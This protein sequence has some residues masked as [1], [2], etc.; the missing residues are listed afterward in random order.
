MNICLVRPRFSTYTGTTYPPMGLLTIAPYFDK[1]HNIIFHDNQTMVGDGRIED[2][3]VMA[4]SAFT[5]QLWFIEETIKSIREL[6]Q[7]KNCKFVVGGP[8]VTSNPEYAKSLVPSADLLFA[9]DGEYLAENIEALVTSETKLIDYRKTPY[10]LDNKKLPSW[11]LI[12]CKPYIKTVGLAVETS[13]GCPFNCVMCTAHLTHGKQWIPRKTKEI[14]DELRTLKQNFGC[15]KFYFADDNATVDP[16][17]WFNLMQTL[18][19]SGLNLDLSVP[20]GIQAHHLDYETLVQMWFAGLRHFTIGAESGSNRVLDKVIG[21]GGLT[22]EKIEWVVRHAI[23]ANLKPSCFFVIG[24]PG[25][26]L[27]EA[28]ATVDFAEKLRRL[29]AESCTVRNAI[30]MPGTRMFEIAK[31]EGYLTVSEDKLFDFNFVHNS[32]HLLST[33]EW[34]AEQIDGLVSKAKA[35]EKKHIIRSNIFKHPRATLNLLIHKHKS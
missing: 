4:F 26:T 2:Y 23:L 24:F 22:V 6:G 10:H 8:G 20:E 28:Q 11:N 13:R 21:K 16:S 32:K 30:P 19:A 31:Q 33:K 7:R 29:G 34:S 27:Q 1:K 9:G 18:G 35:Q 25:E 15:S 17:R 3:D 5:E 14:V 12:D